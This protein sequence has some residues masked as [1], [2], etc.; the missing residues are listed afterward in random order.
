MRISIFRRLILGYLFILAAVLAMGFFALYELQQFDKTTRSILNVDYK[1]IEF[2][3]KLTDSLLSQ[4]RYEGKYM[5][6][7]DPLLFQQFLLARSE[8]RGYLENVIGMMQ[9]DSQKDLLSRAKAEYEAYQNLVEQEAQLVDSGA[10]YSATVYK[11]AKEHVVD[12]ILDELSVLAAFFQDRTLKRIKELGDSG[13]DARRLAMGMAAIALLG[14]IGISFFITRSITKPISFLIEKTREIATGVFKGDLRFSSP[15]EIK[16]LAEAFN[17]MCHQLQEV[18]RMKSDFF[19]TMSHELR[20]PLSA[21]KEGISL[22]AEGVAGEVSEKQKKIMGIMAAETKRLIDLVNSSLDL[23]KMEA[24][25]MSFNFDL[26]EIPALIR[27]AAMEIKPLAIAKEI[28]VRVE[29]CPDLPL[30]RI[31][32]ERILQV[33]RNLLGNA[34]KFTPHK[35]RITVAACR[36]DRSLEVRVVDTGCGVPPENLSSIFEKFHQ[37]PPRG[38]TKMKGTGLGLAIVKHIITAHGGSVWAES[39]LGHGSSFI[40]VLPA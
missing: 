10:R 2:K 27:Q 37:G 24:G 20:T 29:D 9:E 7:K 39:T 3:K 30:I 22:L 11:R 17:S 26:A 19:S 38:G 35:G 16:E 32:R 14:I 18:D 4:M 33:L 23:S 13:A 5:V 15:P 25:K 12:G 8:F 36:K 1:V 31:D 34:V 28:Q 6:S 21:I 40:F